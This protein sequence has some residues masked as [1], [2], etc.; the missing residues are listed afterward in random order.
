MK[1]L[2][3]INNFMFF[4]N[5]IFLFVSVIL[6]FV[7]LLGIIDFDESSILVFF[8]SIGTM[9]YATYIFTIIFEKRNNFKNKKNILRLDTKSI[10]K[11]YEYDDDALKDIDIKKISL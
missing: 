9:F 10:N 11:S 4:L 1:I 5:F 6:I 8:I 3:F 2:K 7:V